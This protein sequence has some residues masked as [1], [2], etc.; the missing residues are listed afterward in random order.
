MSLRKRVLTMM[1]GLRL[2]VVGQRTKAMMCD[3]CGRDV[4]SEEVVEYA[5]KT[6]VRVLVKHHGAEELAT[7]DLGTEHWDDGD[8]SRAMRGHRWFQP[9]T[10]R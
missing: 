8:L 10:K 1:Q 6:A 7:F 3:L 9:E 2:P 4:D 5:G